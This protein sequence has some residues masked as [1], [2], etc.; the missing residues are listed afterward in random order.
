MLVD[1]VAEDFHELLQDGGLTSIALL[2]E[3]GRVVVMAVHVALVLVVR[4]L[5]AENGWANAACEMLDVI[6]AI[7]GGD[8]R[9]S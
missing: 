2:R 4:I 8:V 7:Q 9:A 5:R 6:L 3:L 1:T